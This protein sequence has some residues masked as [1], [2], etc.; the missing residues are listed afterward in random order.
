[1]AE[2]LNRREVV[3]DRLSGANQVQPVTM[4]SVGVRRAAPV[5]TQQPSF[6]M[7]ISRQLGR[8]AQDTL[9]KA[10]KAK[11]ERSFL[12]GQMAYQQGRTIEDMQMDGDKWALEGWRVINAQEMSSGLLMAQQREIEQGEYESNPDAYRDKVVSRMTALIEQAPDERTAELVRNQLMEHMP[13]LVRAHTEAH[14][15]WQ[16]Q[17]AF[18][19]LA[20][21]MDTISRD[22]SAAS[23]L[24]SFAKGEEGS[25]TAG[26]SQL[27]RKE[28]V[29]K[30]I[31]QA[32][33]NG[34]PMPYSIL[35]GTGAIE[36]LSVEQRR[37]I[38]AADQAFQNR[39]RQEYDADFIQAERDILRRAAG[40]GQAAP[41]D[42]VALSKEMEDLYAQRGIDL[43]ASDASNLYNNYDTGM[44]STEATVRANAEAANV[45]KEAGEQYSTKIEFAMGPARPNAPDQPVLDVIGWSVEQV[46]GKG[47]KVRVTSGQEGN[48]PQHGSNRHKTGNAA[49]IQV[50]DPQGNVVTANDPRMKEIARAAAANGAL[51]IGFGQEY[52]GGDHMHID[53]VPP[54]TG[55]AHTWASG[56][57]AMRAELSAIMS[58]N[59]PPG[60][61]VNQ[62]RVYTGPQNY[63]TQADRARYAQ[64]QYEET[65]QR[66]GLVQYQQYAESVQDLDAELASGGIT[67]Q[68]YQQQA[69]VL[70][71]T[72]N[73]ELTQ[74][75]VSHELALRQG[76]A[77]RAA[78]AQLDDKQFQGFR[79][80]QESTENLQRIAN[81]A[82]QGNMSTR[83]IQDAL[84]V[85]QQLRREVY[86]DYDL[87]FSPASEAEWR[88]QADANIKKMIRD[89]EEVRQTD[90]QI[91]HLTS[92]GMLDSAPEEAKTRALELQRKSIAKE[93]QDMAAQGAGPEEQAAYA[94]SAM[95]EFLTTSG[96]VD[97][98]LQSAIQAGINA[99]WL[100]N[101]ELRPGAV[102]A[103]A[104]F[105]RLMALNPD[106]ARQY[107]KD[108]LEGLGK[109]LLTL[110]IA[111]GTTL[112]YAME[113][114][115][116]APRIEDRSEEWRNSFD[117][118]LENAIEH[119]VWDALPRITQ[120]PG[121]D[122]TFEDINSLSAQV[123]SRGVGPNI[124][125]PLIGEINEGKRAD[126]SFEEGTLSYTIQ[127][128]ASRWANAV[129]ATQ[130][131]VRPS[132]AARI[133]ANEVMQHGAILGTGFVM[134]GR[135]EPSIRQQMFGNA[136][137]TEPA[138]MNTAIVRYLRSD[139]V[140][141]ANPGVDNSGWFSD[142]PTYTVT[143]IGNEYWAEVQGSGAAGP[144]GSDSTLVRLPLRQIGELYVQGN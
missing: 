55:Q 8:F 73:R 132:Q 110:D 9:G 95:E 141:E 76:I 127:Q 99:E 39:R 35:Q 108:D 13:T 78:Q 63:V 16:E 29:T 90:A 116:T 136:P 118:E 75:D 65:A 133:A 17:Q 4:P 20:R 38:R 12:D 24:V 66:V 23:A 143:R 112:E 19:G 98:K 122:V 31:I 85:E 100:E 59:T 126:L 119:E 138:A 115:S 40:V 41:E 6:D 54:G 74:N 18:D 60:G 111:Q 79:I 72:F 96:V 56:G 46:L 36:D 61:S 14:Y 107:M 10:V 77:D 81:E 5:N 109:A 131:G 45:R 64:K 128:H 94:Q 34:N 83:D 142:V 49:D 28:A 2:G 82:A 114:V 117:S 7:E 123:G 144:F 32:F 71:E 3:Q 134:P 105:Q 52:M 124:T 47:A 43:T 25:A 26:L 125:L 102:Q 58:G 15:K 104:Q 135:G 30:G 120:V 27:R 37:A 84:N 48:R 129:M 106:Y 86:R 70:R 101:G 103:M 130:P 11:Q 89:R 1:M 69:S 97:P 21:S 92:L 44:A 137:V 93:V 22:P 33:E 87:P 51:G 139:A 140:R 62:K 53:L 91:A 121:A 50:I 67:F 68:Q 88:R 113:T 80:L 42:P 57:E